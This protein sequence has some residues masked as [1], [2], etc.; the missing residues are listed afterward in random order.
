MTGIQEKVSLDQLKQA[1]LDIPIEQCHDT[2]SGYSN[3]SN[4]TLPDA[5]VRVTPSG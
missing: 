4:Q 2:P 3:P 5:N 1:H